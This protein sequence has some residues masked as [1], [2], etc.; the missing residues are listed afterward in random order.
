MLFLK[1]ENLQNNNTINLVQQLAY[2]LSR[3]LSKKEIEDLERFWA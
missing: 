3:I 2:H 1:Y